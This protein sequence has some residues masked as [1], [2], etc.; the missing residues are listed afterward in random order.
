MV[1]AIVE[2][3]VDWL[4]DSSDDEIKALVDDLEVYCRVMLA[5]LSATWPTADD[6]SRI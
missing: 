3:M 2:L 4:V 6:P 5:G 1:G